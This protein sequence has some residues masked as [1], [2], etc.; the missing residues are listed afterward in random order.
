M[1]KGPAVCELDGPRIM[2]PI[3]LFKMLMDFTGHSAFQRSHYPQCFSDPNPSH[4]SNTSRF[5]R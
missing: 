5:V 3:T 4:A 2:G 1:K